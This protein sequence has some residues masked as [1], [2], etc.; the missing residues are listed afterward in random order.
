M[1]I[2]DIAKLAAGCLILAACGASTT[3][4]APSKIALPDGTVVAGAEGWCIDEATTRAG[5]DTA[6]VVLG[7]CAAI[8]GDAFLP[9]PPVPGVVT[10]SLESHPSAMPDGETLQKF[11]ASDAGRAALAVNGKAGSVSVLDTRLEDDLLYLHATDSSA[12]P[13]AS[14]EVWRALFGMGGRFVAVSFYA[15]SGDEIDA[16]EG[17][18]TLEEQVASLRAANQG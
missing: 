6:V 9:Q 5:G 3:R 7:N 14:G 8:A 18:A 15:P 4:N 1:R 11:F 13:G 2:S 17:L 16:D 10:V 12:A